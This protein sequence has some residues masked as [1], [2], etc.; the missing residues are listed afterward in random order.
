[1]YI[2][3][4]MMQK[5]KKRYYILEDRVKARGKYKTTNI[6]YLGTADKILADLQ[7]LDNFR[8]KKP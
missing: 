4:K 1:M 5:S 2:R 7:E 3:N 6:R 8:R